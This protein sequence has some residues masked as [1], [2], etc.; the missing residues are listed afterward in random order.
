MAEG[1][2]KVFKIG[3]LTPWQF[4]KDVVPLQEIFQSGEK[5]LEVRFPCNE[6]I[7]QR[8]VYW[9]GDISSLSVD[10][11]VISTNESL[12]EHLGVSATVHRKAGS[13]LQEECSK[14]EHCRTGESRLT[15]GYKLPCKYIMH[16]VG[17][18][19]S[20]KYEIAAENALHGCYKT[21]LQLAKVHSAHSIA[22]SVIH[23]IRRGYPPTSGA[24]IACRTIRRFLEKYPKPH[25]VIICLENDVD[26]KAYRAVLPMYFPR[27]I[28]E[29]RSAASLLPE[30][31]GNEEGET[32]IEDRRIRI[33]NL[34][35]RSTSVPI[36]PTK[37]SI[38][39]EAR[40]EKAFT[41]F[42]AVNETIPSQ[43][44]IMETKTGDE[45]ECIIL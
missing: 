40:K 21:A 43:L 10:G 9:R 18:R 6:A 44:K 2:E 28:E 4:N 42:V 45:E 31:I 33:H 32:I 23:Q 5:D 27:S 35:S 8:V 15:L 25:K 30:N 16:T 24:H 37:N 17:P 7:N 26:D 20:K 12:T 38:L 36:K 34:T 19:F 22:F 13:Q 29:A 3:D 39:H 41:T 1:K 11:I 14:L